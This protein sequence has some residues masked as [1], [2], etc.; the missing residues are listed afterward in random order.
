MKYLFFMLRVV[1]F[2]AAVGGLCYIY[3]WSKAEVALLTKVL[4]WALLL[5]T[6]LGLWMQFKA[7]KR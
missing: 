5:S 6:S 7:L 2:L 3:F 4:F 1:L